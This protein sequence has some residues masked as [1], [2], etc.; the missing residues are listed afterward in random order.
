MPG[1]DRQLIGR[2]VRRA[3]PAMLANRTIRRA[4]LRTTV[5]NPAAL[6]REEASELVLG[7]IDST[8]YAGSS[9]EMRAGAFEH[10]GSRSRCR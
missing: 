1:R 7:F 4:L 2:R 6:T 10:A 9:E 5:A 8:G 3:V